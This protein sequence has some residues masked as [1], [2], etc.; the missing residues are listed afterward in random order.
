MVEGATER[1][2]VGI[3]RW[4]VATYRGT[5][6]SYSGC[7]WRGDASRRG[8]STSTNQRIISKP[9]KQV[10]MRGRPTRK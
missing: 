2:R 3:E 9:T 6:G 7:D 5:G 10:R 4:L 1:G 8:L